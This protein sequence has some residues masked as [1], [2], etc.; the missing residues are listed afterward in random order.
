MPSRPPQWFVSTSVSRSA[1]PERPIQ[2]PVPGGLLGLDIR[3]RIRLSESRLV[4]ASRGRDWTG[5]GSDALT[6]LGVPSK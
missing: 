5:D 2:D 4:V 1:P 3:A 6:P